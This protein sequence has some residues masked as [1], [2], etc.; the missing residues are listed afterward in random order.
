MAD[1]IALLT[2][3]F[4]AVKK[5]PPPSWAVMLFV[6]GL[7]FILTT[8][9]LRGDFIITS[10]EIY[11]DVKVWREAPQHD[12]TTTYR[13]DRIKSRKR[14]ARYLVYQDYATHGHRTQVDVINYPV[15]QK[16]KPLNPSA[17]DLEIDLGTNSGYGKKYVVYSRCEYID[18]FPNARTETYTVKVSYPTK[19]LKITI[20]LPPNKPCTNSSVT[21]RVGA[22][23]ETQDQLPTISENRR[24]VCW[25]KKNQHSAP[26]T[27][28]PGSG[29][30]DLRPRAV[31]RVYDGWL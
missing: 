21:E 17:V 16:P 11:L 28:F 14:K 3:I 31:R 20:L 13:I 23:S 10:R 4:Q 24:V 18:T 7:V 25:Q 29:R 8:K 15:V 2:F 5:Q 19:L 22:A 30:I 6:L 12:E 1:G 27:Q 26:N 9:P